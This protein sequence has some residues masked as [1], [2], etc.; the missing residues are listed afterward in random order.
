MM[1]AFTVLAPWLLVGLAAGAIP[2]VL[3]LLS[4]VKAQEILFPTLRFLKIS[5]EKTA[6]R[7]RIQH[8]LLL[9]VRTL[10]LAGL[11]FAV[12]RPVSEAIGSW[13][14]KQADAVAIILDNSFSMM[15]RLEGAGAE[16]GEEGTRFG[17]AKAEISALLDG[18]SKPALAMFITSNGQEP[19][20][21]PTTHLDGVRKLIGPAGIG[22]VPASLAQRVTD[23]VE[24]LKRQPNPQKVVYLFGDLQRTSYEELIGLKALKDSPGVHLLIIN[25]SSGQVNNVGISDLKVAGQPVVDSRLEFTVTL[26]NSSPAER[27]TTVGLRINGIEVGVRVSKTLSA[28]GKEGSRGAVRLYH[29]FSQPGPVNGEV[30]LTANDDLDVDNVRRFALDI[31]GRVKALVVRGRVESVESGMDPAMMLR[32]A[33]DPFGD[34]AAAEPPSS[35]PASTGPTTEEAGGRRTAWP[36]VPNVIEAAQ[37]KEDDLKGMDIAFFCEVA[38]FQEAQVEAVAK[39]VRDGGTAAFF[40]GP[41]VQIDNYN[42]LFV[43]NPRVESIRAEGGL[44]PGKLLPAVG[45]VGPDAPALGLNT[46][47]IQHRYFAGLYQNKLDYLSVLVKRHFP[48]A[49]SMRPGNTLMQLA[50]G[51]PLLQVKDFGKGK[52]L[53]FTTT[54]SPKWTNLPTRALFLPLVVRAGL[55]ARQEQGNPIHTAGKQVTI[56]PQEMGGQI[57]DDMKRK[58]EVTLP[59]EEGAAVRTVPVPLEFSKSDGYFGTFR[60][61]TRLGLYRWQVA[62]P[63]LERGASGAFA[64]N[65]PPEESQLEPIGAWEAKAIQ[66]QKTGDA[67]KYWQVIGDNFKRAMKDRGIE[68]VYVGGS[69]A[70]AQEA[71]RGAAN[72]RP[73]LDYV[74]MMVVLL[75]VFE[76][77]VANRKK[78]TEEAVPA[79]LNPKLAP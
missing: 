58:I 35:R 42:Q 25:A 38:S 74:V 15:S 1:L 19:V 76:A 39:F 53:L 40:L 3:H 22:Y 56:R 9:L 6:R 2:W 46:V 14:G 28:F 18:E 7:R 62:V 77:I 68:Q 73:W 33:L 72:D 11:A 20:M 75:L 29:V 24:K 47:D 60:D 49:P 43:H 27:Q 78:L 37:F 34:A 54:A 17:K 57:G 16:K 50:N 63:G 44:L 69:L 55:F 13:A 10:L 5:M 23:A 65:P 21:E 70:E 41:E 51:D 32:L 26:V 30:F 66:A 61:T 52:V 12:A 48:L 36:I 45:E 79:Y 31:G 71:A 59:T 8:W 4:S 64:V 67:R